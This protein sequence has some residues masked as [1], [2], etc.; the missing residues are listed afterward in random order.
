MLF[1][2]GAHLLRSNAKLNFTAS[3]VG[4]VSWR[5]SG[6]SLVLGPDESA[7]SVQQAVQA[8]YCVGV[9]GFG[10]AGAGV[11]GAVLEAQVQLASSRL[12][13]PDALP[14]L[15]CRQSFCSMSR[16][17]HL[18]SCPDSFED[19][20]DVFFVIEYEHMP[21]HSQILGS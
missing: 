9:P 1:Q 19:S 3:C 18:A 11:C 8:P 15:S 17:S 21:A 10:G 16:W 20:A 7:N 12:Q 13:L 5:L 14:F 6:D 2:L 4:F